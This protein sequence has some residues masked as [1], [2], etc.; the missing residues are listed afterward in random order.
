MI[1]VMKSSSSKLDNKKKR[2]IG[3]DIVTKDGFHIFPQNVGRESVFQT[4]RNNIANSRIRNYFLNF[5]LLYVRL[6]IKIF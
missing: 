3:N 1:N 6:L 5:Q 4:F 2:Q